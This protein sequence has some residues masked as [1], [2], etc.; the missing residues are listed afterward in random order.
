MGEVLLHCA[1][2]ILEKG[3]EVQGGGGAVFLVVGKEGAAGQK[4]V[5]DVE[6]GP[7]VG[8]KEVLEDGSKSATEFGCSSS[9]SAMEWLGGYLRSST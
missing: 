7:R 4:G 5:V 2:R 6:G 1:G 9:W 3:P 8:L